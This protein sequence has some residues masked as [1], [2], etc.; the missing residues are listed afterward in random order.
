MRKE[1]FQF[2]C[3]EAEEGRDSFVNNPMSKEEGRVISCSTDHIVVE[4]PGGNK[5][6]WSFD[7]CEELSRSKEE[8]P[9]R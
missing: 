3:N 4:T 6:C 7:E 5:R 1:R 2:V 8:W 9:R